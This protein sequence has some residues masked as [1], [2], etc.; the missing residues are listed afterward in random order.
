MGTQDMGKEYTL[1][2]HLLD[3][4]KSNRMAR[5]GHV[6]STNNQSY[7]YDTGTGKVLRLNDISYAFF[8]ALLAPNNSVATV[9]KVVDHMTESTF[10]E[11]MSTIDAEHLMARPKLVKMVPAS[12]ESIDS[13]KLHQ[14]ILANIAFILKAMT[15]IVILA[16]AICPGKQRKKPWILP[17]N[18]L[19]MTSQF[20][21]MAGNL[22]STWI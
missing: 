15:G 7:L 9:E 19:V 16:I 5:C 12:A 8:D 13:Q 17:L 20:R 10:K 4:K 2:Q 1:Y 14:L 21:F 18:I 22:L 3:L 11:I 6:F